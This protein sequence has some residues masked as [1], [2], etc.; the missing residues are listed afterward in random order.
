MILNIIGDVVQTETIATGSKIYDLARLKKQYRE[1]R[2]RKRGNA[3]IRLADGTVRVV[4]IHWCEAH[5]IGRKE[6]KFKAF[7]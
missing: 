7:L 1:K 6:Y 2:W 3:R 4:A 5:G